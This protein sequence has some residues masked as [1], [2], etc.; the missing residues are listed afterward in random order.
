[1]PETLLAARVVTAFGVHAPGWV[2]IEAGRVLASGSGRPEDGSWCVENRSPV[3]A[4]PSSGSTPPSPGDP[5]VRDLGDATIVPG[6][7][8]LHVHGGGGGSYGGD[9]A[10]V[11]V[12]RD[13]H[14]AHG[15]TS[16]LASLV[17]ESPE[18]LLAQVRRLAELC[19]EREIDGIHLE[20][21]WLSAA[22]AGA[23]AP[24]LLRD[25]DPTEIDALLAAGRGHIRM[26]TIAPE[27]PGAM[28][29]IRRFVEAGVIPAIGHTD[30]DYRTTRRALAAGA[31]A[32]THLFN[33]MR[34]LDHREPGPVLALMEDP[35][36]AVELIADGVHLHPSLV[37]GL[38]EAVG[39]DRVLLVTDA[40]DA[41]A[42][43]DG[44]YRLGDLEVQVRD[45]VARLA[46]SDTIA[47][48]TTTMDALFR[49]A[50]G[51][52][53]SDGDL[54][55]AVRQTSTNQAGLMGWDDIGD[56]VPGMRA[57]LVVL[58]AALR[59]QEVIASGRP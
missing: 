35:R 10:S 11:L 27:L 29:A 34:P 12:A 55:T 8:D 39:Q 50:A 18:R 47:G 38:G 51:A 59:V 2:Q 21:P 32:A 37:A 14:R 52:D 40:M 56:I 4:P 1:M 24:E 9:R 44:D 13:A 31:R 36:V 6:F 33:A 45:G 49:A 30:A 54:V 20:G 22:R 53:P 15:T 17:T 19:D 28:N 58:D 42:H 7:V 16:T 41:A 23:H 43:A 5:F 26:V 3:D 46:G 48:S 25:P 57:D